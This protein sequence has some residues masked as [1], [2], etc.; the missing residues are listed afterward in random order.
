[1]AL[2]TAEVLVGAFGNI[3][4]APVG[5]TAPADFSV[6]YS[7]TWVEMGYA[8]ED[9]VT[10]SNSR[11]TEDINTWQDFD[12]ARTIVTG[13]SVTLG[14]NLLQWNK[15]TLPLAMGGGTI[16]TSGSA[17]TLK[18]QFTPAAAGVLDERAFSVAWNDGTRNYRLFIPRG[19]VTDEV[20]FSLNKSSAAALPISVRVLGTSSGSAFYW[21]TSDGAFA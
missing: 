7:G 19:V 8:D 3:Y 9:G 15:N 21:Y 4:A 20:S 1:V 10:F 6:A 12:P 14:F 2:N 5:T 18:Y 13:R 11:D 16:A 17:G